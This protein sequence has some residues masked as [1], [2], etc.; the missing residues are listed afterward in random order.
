MNVVTSRVLNRAQ[1]LKENQA[2]FS[3]NHYVILGNL[4]RRR[5]FLECDPPLSR[6]S[7]SAQSRLL[8]ESPSRIVHLLEIFHLPCWQWPTWRCRYG[9]GPSLPNV[10]LKICPH[11]TEQTS[12]IW[13]EG[14]AEKKREAV[15]KFL[16]NIRGWFRPSTHT[17]KPSRNP[18]PLIIS[19]ERTTTRI[20]PQNNP[21]R[22]L[23]QTGDAFPPRHTLT[24]WPPG[25]HL[26][27]FPTPHARWWLMQD[28]FADSSERHFR[29]VR[30]H[31]TNWAR[32]RENRSQKNVPRAA[33]RRRGLGAAG[34][35]V[36]G[37]GCGCRKLKRS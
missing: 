37:T 5:F 19:F 25:T 22:F 21:R 7:F 28:A 31:Q 36:T 10:T 3:A 32:R 26:L 27:P 18:L 35:D 29:A 8:L 13:R 4:C 6:G 34:K 15:V 33:E 20:Y 11:S 30:R 23:R 9:W 16:M 14:K 12:E 24:T 17:H 2:S 1:N